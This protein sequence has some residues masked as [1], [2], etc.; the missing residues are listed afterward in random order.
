MLQDFNPIGDDPGAQ[1]SLPAGD[2]LLYPASSPAAA[3]NVTYELRFMSQP[4]LARFFPDNT[5]NISMRVDMQVLASRPARGPAAVRVG[6]ITMHVSAQ[7]AVGWSRLEVQNVSIDVDTAADSGLYVLFQDDGSDGPTKVSTS[8]DGSGI[9]SDISAWL[10]AV[11]KVG[12]EAG[13]ITNATFSGATHFPDTVKQA[14]PVFSFLMHST[15]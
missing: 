6:N 13:N 4:P 11:V 14:S 8:A 9:V 12:M 15:P 5:V 3:G 10:A 7:L 1:A 2:I